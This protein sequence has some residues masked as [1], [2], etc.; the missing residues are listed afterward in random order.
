VTEI[1]LSIYAGDFFSLSFT[2]AIFSWF[3]HILYLFDGVLYTSSVSVPAA[4]LIAELVAGAPVAAVSQ[5]VNLTS[6]AENSEISA[7]IHAGKSF[8]NCRL[9]LHQ[10]KNHLLN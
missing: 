4:F 2:L 8:E 6:H 3:V 10:D 1:I 7:L 5:T 9:F